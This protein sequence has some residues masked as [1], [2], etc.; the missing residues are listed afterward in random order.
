[1]QYKGADKAS[2]VCPFILYLQVFLCCRRRI[3]TFAY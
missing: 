2:G 3:R 1:L